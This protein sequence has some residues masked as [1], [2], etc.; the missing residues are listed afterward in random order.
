MLGFGILIFFFICHY[1]NI[2]SFR[3]WGKAVPGAEH[4]GTSVEEGCGLLCADA[5]CEFGGRGMDFDEDW[6][7]GAKERWFGP[8]RV[9]VYLISITERSNRDPY[10]MLLSQASTHQGMP[11]VRLRC[12]QDNGNRALQ[13]HLRP[14]CC[15]QS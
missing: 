4:R 6:L 11:M 3:K 8:A 15:P 10:R 12:R 1:L 9:L 2:L 7:P 14:L 5:D 13:S